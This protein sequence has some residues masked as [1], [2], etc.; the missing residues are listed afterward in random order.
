MQRLDPS[1]R[2]EG[3]LG[4]RPSDTDTGDQRACR[5]RSAEHVERRG[6]QMAHDG[7]DHRASRA[8]FRQTHVRTGRAAG[9]VRQRDAGK[10]G[11]RWPRGCR[12]RSRRTPARK[13]RRVIPS[14]GRPGR[15]GSERIGWRQAASAGAPRS[16]SGPVAVSGPGRPPSWWVGA[17]RPALKGLGQTR[18]PARVRDSPLLCVG[19]HADSF[20]TSLAL[21]LRPRTVRTDLIPELDPASDGVGLSARYSSTGVVGE[22]PTPAVSWAHGSAV[23]DEMART[24]AELATG[25]EP[26][27]GPARRA[28]VTR[29]GR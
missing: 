11:R 29:A 19:G 12:R 22:P 20:G 16:S 25:E 10:L 23:V 7:H 13:R 24:F 21:H 2:P 17:R 8:G 5:Q 3:W 18:A 28:A 6:S 1:Q 27:V 9:A 15:P 4:L 14:L 26:V